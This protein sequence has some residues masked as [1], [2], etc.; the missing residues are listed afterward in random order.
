MYIK[1]IIVVIEEKKIDFYLISYILEDRFQYMCGC[2]RVKTVCVCVRE[3]R[4]CTVS[5]KKER[6]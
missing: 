1:R 4:N 5:E 3:G 2:V 6:V